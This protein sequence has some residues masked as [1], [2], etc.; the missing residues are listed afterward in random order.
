[1]KLINIYKSAKYVV[2]KKKNIHLSSIDSIFQEGNGPLFFL[3]K[4][5]RSERLKENPFTRLRDYEYITLS[6]KNHTYTL[7]SSSVSFFKNFDK[8]IF[9]KDPKL[10]KSIL[11]IKK[12]NL[13]P[14]PRKKLIK[15]IKNNH[16]IFCDL[17]F[18]FKNKKNRIIAKC[19]YL[20]FS[21]NRNY[22]Q[23][24][25]K[26]VLKIKNNFHLGYAAVHFN[27][28]KKNSGNLNLVLKEHSGILNNIDKTWLKKII[29]F[30][31]FFITKNDFTKVITINKYKIKFYKS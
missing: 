3:G 26:T 14:I 5:C 20:N 12:D 18:M 1:M 23:P 21:E 7:R 2:S 9:Q 15:L 17:T 27:E 4:E 13:N 16:N 8:I 6:S 19:E 24:I 11:K 31:F 29:N 30:L 10:N 28:D 22:V 25:F